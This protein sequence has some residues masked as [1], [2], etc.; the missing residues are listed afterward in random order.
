[1]ISF[2]LLQINPFPRPDP[3]LAPGNF[4]LKAKSWLWAVFFLHHNQFRLAN[5]GIET[6][7]F[8]KLS[9]SWKVGRFSS[10]ELQHKQ[11]GWIGDSWSLK[12]II[13]FVFIS[14]LQSSV[15]H[16]LRNKMF[17]SEIS[18]VQCVQSRPC[19]QIPTT[20]HPDKVSHHAPANKEKYHSILG[21]RVGIVV[22]WSIFLICA[23]W[24]ILNWS[25][26]CWK[27]N[28][29][30]ECLRWEEIGATKW[31]PSDPLSVLM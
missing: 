24:M 4:P 6:E 10:P 12:N 7:N 28:W 5:S 25:H 3:L 17:L 30:F 22:F 18:G 16:E 1:M 15:W 27:T 8:P 14:S 19:Q 13:D 2:K 29:L 26:Q 20:T 31:G 23:L 11:P 21:P 9:A